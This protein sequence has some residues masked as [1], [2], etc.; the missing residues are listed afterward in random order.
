M[1]KI[2]NFLKSNHSASNVFKNIE[3]KI[4]YS[5]WSPF[6][7]IGNAYC[8]FKDLVEFL[9]LQVFPNNFSVNCYD[10]LE[11]TLIPIG[12]NNDYG[13]VLN[14]I[15]LNNTELFLIVYIIDHKQTIS[16]NCSTRSQEINKKMEKC[17]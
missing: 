8:N 9:S 4:K 14:N 1:N 15:K 7:S 17:K 11:G 5:E 3:C 12:N 16:N 13:K 6:E 2:S 10:I